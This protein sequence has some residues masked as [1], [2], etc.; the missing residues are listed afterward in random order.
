[1]QF[2]DKQDKESEEYIL[3]NYNKSSFRIILY[4][5]LFI[6]FITAVAITGVILDIW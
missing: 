6:I 4:V 2:K 1:M 3:Q 5:I